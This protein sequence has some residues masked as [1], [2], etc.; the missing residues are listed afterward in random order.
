MKT[1][2]EKLQMLTQDDVAKILN[3]SLDNVKMLRELKIIKAIKTGK[4]YMFSQ[5]E[6]ILFQKQY[7]GY[8]VSNRV[9]AVQAYEDVNKVFIESS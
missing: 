8:D 5:E 4:N 6:L 7:A 9:K 1:S 2:I 3:V